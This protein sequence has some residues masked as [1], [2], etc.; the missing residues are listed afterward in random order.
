M[1]D[2]LNTHRIGAS[3]S[4]ALDL[5][6][7]N[8][9]DVQSA[10]ARMKRVRQ[11]GNQYTIDQADN[12]VEL[13][14]APR[15]AQGDI[16]AGWNLSLSPTQTAALIPGVYSIDVKFTLSNSVVITESSAYF[17]MTKGTV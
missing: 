6:D 5:I 9:S 8:V 1:T 12:G 10:V 16:P 11:R 13:T 3:F 14:I 4:V 17:A 15:V 7:G 2:I